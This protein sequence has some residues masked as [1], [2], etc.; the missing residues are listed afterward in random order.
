MITEVDARL[1]SELA[2]F[3]VK[4]C[5][6]DCTHFEAEGGECSLG[7]RALDHRARS[8]APG[9]VIVFCKTFELA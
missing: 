2:E 1:R 8:I 4:Y 3:R 5:C 6:E 9:D 7:Y